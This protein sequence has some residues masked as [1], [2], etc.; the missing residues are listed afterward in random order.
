[1]LA[2]STVGEGRKKIWSANEDSKNDRVIHK[3][4]GLRVAVDISE[5][6][7]QK[8]PDIRSQFAIYL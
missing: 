8:L 3:F 7:F 2:Y 6:T 5:Q 4:G 1:M